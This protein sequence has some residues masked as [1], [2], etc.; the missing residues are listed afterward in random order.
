MI[1]G[2]RAVTWSPLTCAKSLGMSSKTFVVPS[3]WLM[4]AGIPV[5]PAT[6][7]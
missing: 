1:D 5:P 7:G 4:L 6:Q 3:R 2:S